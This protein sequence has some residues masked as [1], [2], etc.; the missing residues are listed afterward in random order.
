MQLPRGL[1]Q[2]PARDPDSGL[3]NVLIDT[4]KGSRN[5]YKFDETLALFRLRKVLPLGASSPRP[6]PKTVTPW[7]SWY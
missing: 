6:A 2:V 7:T 4:P 5:K 3:V 1:T